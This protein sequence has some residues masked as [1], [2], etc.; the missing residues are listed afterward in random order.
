[1]NGRKLVQGNEACVYG[2]LAA[3]VRFYAGYPITPSTEIAEMMATELPKY[4]GTYIQMEDEI[5]SMGAVLGASMA[6]VKAMTATSGPGFSLMQENIGYGY[7]A[8]VPC[9]IVNVQRMGPSTGVPTAPGQADV[10]Q[11]RWGTHGDHPALVLTPWSVEECYTLT[12]K[13]VELSELLSMPV[14]LLM[15]EVIGHMRESINIAEELNFAQK[16]ERALPALSP[17][18][19]QPYRADEKGRIQLAPFGHG[20]RYH[21]TGLAHDVK[22][23]PTNNPKLIEEQLVRIQRKVELNRQEI[24]LYETYYADDADYLLVSY[25][26]SARS[27]F[28]TMRKLR[29]NGL[30]VGLVR[31]ITLWPLPDNSL[32][33]IVKNKKRV[34][35]VEMNQGQI[36]REI[37]RVVAGLCKVQGIHRIDGELITP[38]EILEKVVGSLC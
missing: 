28:A 19:Y 21:I 17:Q 30:K 1:M 10:Q 14:I 32:R 2:A 31:L 16:A 33:N 25:G 4:Q 6:G 13:A 35:V 20:Y 18:E 5:A 22:G 34:F 23:F 26:C 37:E 24:E 29:A 8:E 3:G 38:N 15:D 9:L 12:K 36:T 27:A 11:A 7:M